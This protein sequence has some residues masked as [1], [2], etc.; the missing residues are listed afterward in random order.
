MLLQIAEVFYYAQKA[1]LHPTAPLFDQ[2][3]QTLKPRCVRALKRIFILCDHDRDGA[4]NDPELN[5]FQV[6]Q[7]YLFSFPVVNMYMEM[8]WPKLPFIC[9][10]VAKG[11]SLGPLLHAECIRA[12]AFHHVMQQC[13]STGCM[14]LDSMPLHNHFETPECTMQPIIC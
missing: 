2:E 8:H 11:W 4:L 12:S 3:T 6:S 5:D 13:T 7:I 9:E 14:S 1:I 10:L